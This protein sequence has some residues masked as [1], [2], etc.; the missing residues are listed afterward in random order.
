M[1]MTDA[2][3]SPDAKRRYNRR[4]F[5]II[6]PRYDF[7]TRLLSYGQDQRWK[8]RL[9]DLAAVQPGERALDVACGTGDLVRL[10]SAAG[11]RVV[12]VD[13]TPA[14]LLIARHR[15]G[16]SRGRYLAGDIVDLPFAAEA[17]DL[18]TAG[19]A[20]RN[21]PD[22]DGGLRELGRVL[23]PG[24]RLLALDFNRPQCGPLRAA[25]LGYLWVVGS[26]LG[27]ILHGDADTYRYIAASLSRYPAAA[28]VAGRMTAA[29]FDHAGWQPVLGGLMAFHFAT[30]AAA[31]P[32]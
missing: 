19:Y 16:A 28:T 3:S 22:L 14:M 11:A 7:I 21:L 31:A 26:T 25:Y 17:F 32:G 4:M 15:P 12:G 24:G 27:T 23:R 1:R 9:V 2:L 30:R 29:G 10:L 6:A 18:V 13:L 8:R 5:E 20:L